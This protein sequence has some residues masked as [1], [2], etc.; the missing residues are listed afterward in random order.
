VLVWVDL[1]PNPK[2]KSRKDLIENI[3]Y[4]SHISATYGMSLTLLFSSL[5]GYIRYDVRILFV[6]RIAI[7]HINLRSI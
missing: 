7:Q 2:K 5:R 4:T 6:R 1:V 3:R